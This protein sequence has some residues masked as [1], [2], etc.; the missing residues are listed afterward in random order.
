MR[1]LL[2]HRQNSTYIIQ[3]GKEGR[4]RLKMLGRVLEPTTTQFLRSLPVQKGMRCLDLGCGG[5]DAT[6]LI[7]KVVEG[8]G[9][10]V[11]GIDLDEGMLEAARKE[12]A[13]NTSISFEKSSVQDFRD[14]DVYG[15]VFARFFLT[16]LV[17]P[18]AGVAVMARAAKRGGI[19]AAEDIDFSNSSFSYPRSLALERYEEI[20]IATARTRGVDPDIGRKLPHLFKAAGLTGVKVQ[21]QQLVATKENREAGILHAWTLGAISQSAVELGVASQGELDA[22]ICDLVE[23]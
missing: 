5:G 20:Y 11:I 21:C 16:H 8:Y 23:L 7:A 6:R 4:D 1:V 19:V 2:P 22:V 12:L 14:S 10:S 17:D 18:A 15:L 3:G 13:E 9:G